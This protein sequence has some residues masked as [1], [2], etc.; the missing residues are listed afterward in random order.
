[1]HGLGARQGVCGARGSLGHSGSGVSLPGASSA[2]RQRVVSVRAETESLSP[3]DVLRRENELLKQTINDA[4]VSIKDLESSLIDANVPVQPGESYASAALVD[5]RSLQP[6]DYWSPAIDVPPGYVYEDEYGPITPMPNHDGTECLKWDDTLWSHAD[7]FRYRW[8][9]LRN[10]RNA[11]DQNEGGLEKF[12]QGWKY[13]GF[14]RGEC[15]GK[16]GIWFREWAPGAKALA[17]VGEFNNWEPQPEHW[18]IKND[19]G[20][21]NLF[22]PD[23]P[24]GTSAIPH[25]TKVKC[26]VETISGAWVEKIPAWIKWATQ[27]WNEVLFNGVYWEPPEV[28]AP[29]EVHTDKKYTFKYPRPPR[30]RALRIYECHVGMSS[31]E[32]KV[33][34]YLEF[35][36]DMLPRIRRLGYN[37]I[38][39]MAIQEHAYYGSFGYHV[40]NFFGASSRCGTPE[41]L[42]ALI[43]EAHRLGMIV[44]MDI[45]HSHASKNTNDGINMFDG[46]DGMYF[47]SGARGNHWMWDSR[48]FNYGNWE[49]MR[50]LLSNARWWMDEYKF[51]GYRFDGVTSMMYHHHGLSYAF[52]G[53]YD[54]YFGMNTDVDAV[55][56]MMLMNNMI[57][58]LF[59]NAVVIGEDVSGMPTFCRPWYEGGVGFDFRLNMAIA[60][61][62]IDIM[63]LSDYDWGMGDLVHTMTNRRYAEACVGYAESHDQALVGDKT[64]AFWLMDKEMYDYMAAPGSGPSSPIIDRGIALHKMIRLITMALGGESYLSFMGNEFGHPEWIDFPRDDTYDP[65]T[66]AFVPGNGGSLEKCRRRWDLCDADFLKYKFLVAFDRAMT[67]L[68]KAFGFMSAPHQWVSRKDEADKMVVIE[69]GDLVMVFNFHP[70][71]SYTDYRV[72]CNNPGPYR[73]V[74]SSDEEVFGGWRNLSKETDGEHQ[75]Q[76]GNHDNRPNSFMVYAPSRTCAV[77]APS[78]WAD[79]EADRKPAGIPGLGVK[80]LGPYYEY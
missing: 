15:D 22:L 51:D 24:D 10:I 23:R 66:G 47:H 11:I 28:G 4:Q 56:Y 52:T 65:S 34:S 26:R 68:D 31:E 80:E 20:V 44:L 8:N 2:R 17:L 29:G 53:H 13:Y 67:H 75:T 57:H 36:R 72:G 71:Q 5:P 40:T 54:E 74:L 58:D 79:A 59:P 73:L 30:P 38:Q 43:D 78:E 33:N 21:W 55:V 27:E 16:K 50:F 41:E 6:E 3:L 12:S 60:D 69:R 7:H 14:N 62:W 42:K 19:F 1:M 18:A 32:P 39:I 76:G 37:A 64:I 25:R 77:Y 46:T 35:R 49:T 70:V 61:K 9:I 45:V 48:L 63:K